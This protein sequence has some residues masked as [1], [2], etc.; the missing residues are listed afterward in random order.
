M[1]RAWHPEKIAVIATLV[2]TSGCSGDANQSIRNRRSSEPVANTTALNPFV[3]WGDRITLQENSDV[4]NV[5]PQ[6][7]LDGA[8]NFLV[9]DAKESQVRV[10]GPTGRLIHHFGGKGGGPSEFNGPIAAMRRSSEEIIVVD[11]GGKGAIFSSDGRDVMKTF[12]LPLGPLYDA[13]LV[14]DSVLL[15]AGRVPGKLDTP[16]LHLFNLNSLSL[17]QSFFPAPAISGMDKMAEPT[18]GFAGSA[19]RGDTIAAVYALSDT[20]YLFG[21]DGSVRGKVPM[22][23]RHFRRMK[24]PAPAPGSPINVVRDWIASFSLTSHV[25]WAPSGDFLVQYQDREGPI[26]HWR[27]TRISRSGKPVFDVRDTPRLLAAS[28]EG[29]T[30]YFISPNSITPDTWTTAS[31]PD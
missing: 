7:R 9:A 31:L 18:V 30:L 15:L 5:A 2:L 6:V 24:T 14:N 22:N 13:N 29:S 4:I 16:L 10:Y 21:L 3:Q 11:R 26:L 19:V 23:S 1:L 17:S 20:V 27:L 28:N 25:F 8:G 12:R